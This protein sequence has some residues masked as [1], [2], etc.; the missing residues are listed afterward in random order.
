MILEIVAY[1]DMIGA[2]SRTKFNYTVLN[3]VGMGILEFITFVISTTHWFDILLRG[4]AEDKNL[5]FTIYPVLS[6]VAFA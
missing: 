2:N 3:I 5:A 4:R 6:I 1:A